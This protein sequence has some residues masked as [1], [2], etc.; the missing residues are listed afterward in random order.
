[1]R[2]SNKW[3]KLARFLVC[4]VFTLLFMLHS[5]GRV[6]IPTLQ[7]I[8]NILYDLRLRTTTLNTIDSHIVIVDINEE[9]LAKEGRWPWRRDKIGYLVDMLFDY[10]AI[11]L[12]GF[13]VIFAEPDTTEGSELLDK[14]ATDTL[15]NNTDFLKAIKE[16]RPQL[17]YDDIF[18]KSLQHRPI[19]LG[20]FVSHIEEKVAQV[21]LL[22]KAVAKANDLPFSSLLFDAKSYAGN[23]AKL[24]T[25]VLSGG[26]FDNPSVDEDG[27][28]R[29]LPLLVCYH[30]N[31]YES[32]SLAMLRVLLHQSPL[33]FITQSGYALL[34]NNTAEVDTRL[35]ALRVSTI[36]IPV[37]EHSEILVPFRGRQGSFVYVS[38]TDVLN[39]IVDKTVLENKIVIIGTTAA[40]L[41]DLRATPVQNVYAGVEIHANILSGLLEQ[42]IKS[43]PNIT[44]VSELL[45]L[46]LIYCLML[47]ILP[48]LSALSSALF[49]IILLTLTIAI[50]FYCWRFYHIAT[51]LAVPII[52]LILL[53]GIQIFFGF[54]LESRKKKQLGTIFGQYI[55]PELVEQMSQSDEEFSLQGESRELTVFFSDVRGFTTISESM[56]PQ[57]LCEL[58]NAILTPVTRVIHEAKGTIDKY[59]GDA[60]MAFWG[61]PLRNAEHA[62]Y[63]VNAGLTILQTLA[64]LRPE[65]KA[66]GWPDIDVGIGINTGQMS[67]GNMGSQFRIAYTVMGDAV[68][69]GSRLEGL[70]KQYG[71]KIIVSESTRAAATGF[72]YRELDRVRVKGKY[73]PITIY[74]PL[75]LIAAVANEQLRAIHVLEQGLQ[76]YRQ[77]QWFAAQTVFQQL[78]R[79]YPN[80]KLYAI[81]LERITHYLQ[82]PPEAD[83]DGAFTHTSK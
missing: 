10:Y 26:F 6:N 46:L 60:I 39:G 1:M 77:Q 63:A 69:L 13:D 21:G 34:P 75:G 11:S 61:A 81:Y 28:Y 4:T 17:A 78:A 33:E 31:I 43:R 82:S 18:A 76:Y 37:N 14:L 68:N 65:F 19:V 29:K 45:E 30:N 35:E 16:L 62:T 48:Y 15:K 56:S 23:L 57:E 2:M 47:F 41:L 8:D 40:G 66:K 42:T 59:I 25:A 64:A 22:P 80:D 36:T 58:I 50:N 83:W 49:F 5:A 51:M 27:V 67:V 55:P 71:V 79:Q 70:T 7:R 3:L 9:S 73:K 53:Y 38:A 24:Q 72:I 74:E 32:L 52:L 12:L 54:F 44:L 20:Y